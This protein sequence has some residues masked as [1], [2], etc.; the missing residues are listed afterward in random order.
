MAECYVGEIRM[1]GGNYAPE[2]WLLCDGQLLS[3][4][5]YETLFVLLGTTYGGDGATT[6]A[7]PDLRG[8]VPIHKSSNYPLGQSIGTEQVVLNSNQLPVHTHQAMGQSAPGSSEAPENNFWSK[9]PST[10][11]TFT[12]STAN[13]TAMNAAVSP[14]GGN[15][16]HDN[17]MPFVAVSFIISTAG[18]FPSQN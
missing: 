11:T 7:L 4:S 12:T 8:R 5:E 17:M 6:F 10:N 15:Q 13:L 18:I 14:I 9:S 3:I 16:P 2:N 1:F